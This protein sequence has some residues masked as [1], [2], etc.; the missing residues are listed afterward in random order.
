LPSQLGSALVEATTLAIIAGW[1]VCGFGLARRLRRAHGTER[2]QVKWFVFA[3]LLAFATF[4]PGFWIEPLFV[5]ATLIGFPAIPLAAGIAILRYRLYDIDRL[6]NRTV[7]YAAASGVLALAYLAVVTMIRAV[8]APWTG[9][10]AVAVAASTL[11]VAALFR[12]VRN[13]VQ[14]IVDR[15]FNRARYDAATTVE[16]VRLSLRDEVDLD[17]LKSELITAVRATMEPA[18][19]TL[20]L[21]E[22]KR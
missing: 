6:I 10:T 12:P 20:W 1:H 18:G 5:F 4:F 22:T 16:R 15:R 9:D 7:V 17:R 8:T 3:V 19:T 2:A 13:R 14:D 11:A 21:R